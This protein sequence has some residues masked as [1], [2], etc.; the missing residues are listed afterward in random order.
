[1]FAAWGGLYTCG[2]RTECQRAALEALDF[3]AGCDKLIGAPGSS[4]D[5]FCHCDFGMAG[6]MCEI[7]TTSS[8][9]RAIFCCL[10]LPLCF[11]AV[12]CALVEVRARGKPT[13]KTTTPVSLS[14][15][16]GLVGGVLN[17]LLLT[18]TI[19]FTLHA[20]GHA[21]LPGLIALAAIQFTLIV[22]GTFVCVASC[23]VVILI[24]WRRVADAARIG[25]LT[26]KQKKNANKRRKVWFSLERGVGVVLL[27]AYV[28]FAAML[29]VGKVQ[30]LVLIF[31]VFYALYACWLYRE[32]NMFAKILVGSNL[33]SNNSQTIAA[34]A[35]T[36]MK[37]VSL[38]LWT[39]VV[40]L[41]VVFLGLSLIGKS[42][43]TNQVDTDVFGIS[44]VHLGVAA[45]LIR[46]VEYVRYN[47]KAAARQVDAVYSGC[48]DPNA[49]DRK[50]TL[51]GPEASQSIEETGESA[52]VV[53]IELRDIGV[54]VA[55]V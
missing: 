34:V 44:I 12:V 43:Y 28:S 27:L 22:P 49:T 39:M 36:A 18:N 38:G 5:M 30:V 19:I 37:Q 3:P 35:R 26:E 40:G 8:T 51:R 9:L 55:Q 11:Y 32:V 29:A 42:L 54:N 15:W 45:V 23:S 52:A 53:D 21:K 50:S 46:S 4:S 48:D 41:L 1:M 7:S 10:L 2:S 17:A 6:K 20:V 47:R 25:L 14:L 31:A 33:A 13:W 16:F 24:A